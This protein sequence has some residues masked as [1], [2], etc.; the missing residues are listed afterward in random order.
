[1]AL[2][3]ENNI[4]IKF[5][6]RIFRPKYVLL[7]NNDVVVDENFLTELVRHMESDQKIGIT[8]PKV[9]YYNFYGR[10]DVINFAGEDLIIWKGQG[11]RYGFNEIDKGQHDLIRNVNKIDGACMLIRS[12]VFRAIGLLDPDYFA[13]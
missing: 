2:R 3:K 8:G 11:I 9:Y 7:L 5:A 10:R 6:L 13:Y 4:A 12:D 1:M